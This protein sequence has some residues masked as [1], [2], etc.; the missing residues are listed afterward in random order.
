LFRLKRKAMKRFVG[1]LLISLV[2]SCTTSSQEGIDNQNEKDMPTQSKAKSDADW[3]QQLSDAEYRVLRQCG[4]E[5]P[6][7]GQYYHFYEEGVYRCAACGSELFGSEKK[8][9]SGSGW[10]SF[11]DVLSDTSV[12]KL[13]DTSHGMHRVEVRCAHCGGHLGHV[14][15]DGPA[16]TF[17]RYC[18]N[19]VALKFVP[20]QK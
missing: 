16:P 9:D 17:K 13:Q 6:G 15:T 3:K 2:L 19:S 4:T 14:F 10:P 12:V 5:A 1:F 20:A 11:W 18:I 7:S 8:Y